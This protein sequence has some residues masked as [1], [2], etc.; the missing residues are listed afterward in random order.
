M[1]HPSHPPA[2]AFLCQA[3]CFLAGKFVLCDS[4]H[5]AVL[6]LLDADANSE[7]HSACLEDLWSWASDSSLPATSTCV[8]RLV[9]HW[10]THNSTQ[11]S[12][13]AAFF[14]SGNSSLNR[15]LFKCHAVKN[16]FKGESR[17]W[18]RWENF[19]ISMVILLR[20]QDSNISSYLFC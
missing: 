18:I 5:S 10:Y 1:Q 3:V 11:H 6:W 17:V 16:G 8:N 15:S 20:K 12:Q 14:P 4:A 9:N 19:F 2:C 7:Q 13:R